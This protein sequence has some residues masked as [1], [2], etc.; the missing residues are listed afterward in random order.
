MK[1]DIGKP[2]F[3][4]VIIIAAV[5]IVW[6]GWRSMETP[7][8]RGIDEKETFLA[9]ERTA[10]SHGVDIKTVP[11]WTAL[12]YKYHPEEKPPTAPRPSG[13]A[14]VMNAPPRLPATPMSAK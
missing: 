2:A 1:K 10:K 5:A 12:Y 8:N 7:E 14:P 9:A 6:F 11:G 4:I 3:A 13:S